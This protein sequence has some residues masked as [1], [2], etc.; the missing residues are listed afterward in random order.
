MVLRENIFIQSNTKR[1]AQGDDR[2]SQILFKSDVLNSPF[3]CNASPR[4]H[5]LLPLRHRLRRSEPECNVAQ[6][7]EFRW[8]W[9]WLVHNDVSASIISTFYIPRSSLCGVFMHCT[10]TSCYHVKV[11]WSDMG[12]VDTRES[13]RGPCQSLIHFWIASRL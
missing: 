9:S 13:V 2:S 7:A 8:S 11:Y 3:S 1:I 12:S 4:P 5:K 10:G 6:R